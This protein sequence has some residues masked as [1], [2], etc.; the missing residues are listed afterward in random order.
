MSK[1]QEKKMQRLYELLSGD[2]CYI[3]GE[4]E[5]GPNG[6]KKDYLRI[7]KAFLKE[8]AKDLGLA[9]V[10]L[11]TMPGGI[12]V[13]GEISL[14]GNWERGNGLYVMLHQ[15]NS[16][17]PAPRVLYRSLHDEC[18]ATSGNNCYLESG[19]FEHQDYNGFLRALLF[20][21]ERGELRLAKEQKYADA[22]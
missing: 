18:K 11:G 14:M 5:S 16:F 9:D 7:G 19:Y 22:A 12:A 4:K 1:L 2:L 17:Y 8:L 6:E 13:A 15:S 3:H 21:K 10:K 20:N